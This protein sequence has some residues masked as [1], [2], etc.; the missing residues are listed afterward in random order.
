MPKSGTYEVD[1]SDK[2]AGFSFS[3]FDNGGADGEYSDEC[4]GTLVFTAPDGMM[5]IIN[6]DGSTESVNYDY[7]SFFEAD[8]EV[9]GN[10]NRV[11]LWGNTWNDL[12]NASVQQVGFVCE[13]D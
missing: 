11:A 7:L 1:L 4:N 10:E 5:F 6:G 12:N 2:E 3:L 13:W 9:I 8:D